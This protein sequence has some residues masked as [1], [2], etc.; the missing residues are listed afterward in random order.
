MAGLSINSVVITILAVALGIVMVGNLL[1]PIAE[2]V[3]TSLTDM[4]DSGAS[5]ATMV[6]VVVMV[7]ILGLIVVAINRFTKD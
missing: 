1:A 6:G 3:M 5:W 4:G 7:S 2:E